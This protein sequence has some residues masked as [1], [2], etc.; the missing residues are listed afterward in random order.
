MIMTK[1][2]VRK[3]VEAIHARKNTNENEIVFVA[4]H[5]KPRM[6]KM[7]YALKKCGLKII[8]LL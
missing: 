2:V 6:V 8:L 3:A 1:D 4:D 7:G 5:V